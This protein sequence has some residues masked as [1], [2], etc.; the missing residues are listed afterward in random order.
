MVVNAILGARSTPKYTQAENMATNA[1][2]RVNQ[3]ANML[4]VVEYMYLI[5]QKYSI[6]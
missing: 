3:S 4:I 2:N 1:N 5:S 6:V